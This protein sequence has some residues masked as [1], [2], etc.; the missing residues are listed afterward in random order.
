MFRIDRKSD[1]SSSLGDD[2]ESIEEEQNIDKAISIILNDSKSDLYEAIETILLGC[3]TKREIIEKNLDNLTRRITEQ[4]L[5][6]KTSHVVRAGLN[7]LKTMFNEFG[8]RRGM[9]KYLDFIVPALISRAADNQVVVAASSH[10]ATM[11]M[12]ETSNPARL[13]KF[14]FQTFDNNATKVKAAHYV[15][16]AITRFGKNLAADETLLSNVVKHIVPWLYERN[17]EIREDTRNAIDH[18]IKTAVNPDN[19]KK[20]I[21]IVATK[22]G[23]P[24]SERLK[25]TIRDAI[26]STKESRTGEK[27]AQKFG[28]SQSK[29]RDPKKGSKITIPKV[30][31]KANRRRDDSISSKSYSKRD[32]GRSK[33]YSV[34]TQFTSPINKLRKKKQ[35]IPQ[36]IP[37]VDVHDLYTPQDNGNTKFN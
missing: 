10:C 9:D 22:D 24:L 12:I 4:I 19:I 20:K 3:T 27:H 23:N 8:G 31:L 1:C 13:F 16:E 33:S 34:N 29:L 32:M 25:S 6:N 21:E 18:L 5:K 15:Y 11:K 14:L 7:C 37:Q 35:A 36:V 17:P 2:I 26:Q 28:R 30:F